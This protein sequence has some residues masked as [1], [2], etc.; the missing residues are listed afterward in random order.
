MAQRWCAIPESN[1][2][3]DIVGGHDVVKQGRSAI[4]VFVLWFQL[5]EWEEQS[6]PA[7]I[8][9]Q[10]AAGVRAGGLHAGG[11]A[12]LLSVSTIRPANSAPFDDIFFLIMSRPAP[13]GAGSPDSCLGL[14]RTCMALTPS[15]YCERA[16]EF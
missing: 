1:T 12:R 5:L 4:D 3:V 10:F 9:T 13:M 15:D 6:V 2:S 7:P 8:V 14:F 11:R 16:N